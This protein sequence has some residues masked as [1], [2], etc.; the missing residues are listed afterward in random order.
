MTLFLKKIE[1]HFHVFVYI[2]SLQSLDMRRGAKYFCHYISKA[3]EQF[4]THFAGKSSNIHTRLC[5]SGWYVIIK[6]LSSR[7]IRPV[8]LKKFKLYLSTSASQV[9]TGA[10]RWIR[11]QVKYHNSGRRWYKLKLKFCLKV[12]V[13]YFTYFHSIACSDFISRQNA[14]GSKG[15]F[16]IPKE[17]TTPKAGFKESPPCIEMSRRPQTLPLAS[18][19]QLSLLPFLLH[20]MDKFQTH[21][22][23]TYR[24]YT[25]P[26]PTQCRDRHFSEKCLLSSSKITQ[27]SST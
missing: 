11:P 21:N 6:R 9:S 18:V 16:F 17:T 12:A 19:F 4:R 24:A 20:T 10:M 27:H 14:A 15:V 2:C 5:N 3:K 26:T 22:Q 7:F 23:I 1:V 25:R 13:A 8:R